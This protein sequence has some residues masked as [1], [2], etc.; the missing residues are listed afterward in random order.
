MLLDR[1]AQE[2]ASQTFILRDQNNPK[3]PEN[4]NVD[5]L[6]PSWASSPNERGGLCGWGGLKSGVV[7][8][9][10]PLG[11]KPAEIAPSSATESSRFTKSSCVVRTS[12]L[13]SVILVSPLMV[14]IIPHPHVQDGAAGADLP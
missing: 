8:P 2:F 7:E 12:F 3:P 14:R 5:N 6:R 11:L 9:L 13:G 1:R 10:R 4:G